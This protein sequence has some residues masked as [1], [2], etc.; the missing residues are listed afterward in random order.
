MRTLSI[1]SIAFVAVLLMGCEG[2][3]QQSYFLENATSD[4]VTVIHAHSV[5]TDGMDLDTVSIAAGERQELGVENW[6]GGR[7]QP[8]LPAAFIDTLIV[9]NSAGQL[10]TKN[11]LLMSEWEIE[12]FEDRKVP[13]QWRHE[14]TFNVTEG[15][16]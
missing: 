4:W 3:T 15:D 8:D 10:C 13:S 5:F 7:E 11:W 1:V 9:F 2:N 6:L 12:S 14:Y 16:F